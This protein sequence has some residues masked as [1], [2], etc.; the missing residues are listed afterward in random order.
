MGVKVSF[1]WFH[2]V[3]YMHSVERLCRLIGHQ[4]NLD[5]VFWFIM[6]KTIILHSRLQRNYQQYNLR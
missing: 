4:F 3:L 2:L 1:F 6:F 5:L